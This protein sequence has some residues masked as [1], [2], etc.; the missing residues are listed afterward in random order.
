MKCCKVQV[1]LDLIFVYHTG[2][3]TI[4]DKLYPLD[5]TNT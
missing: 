4:F 2:I 1:S 5:N 3:F